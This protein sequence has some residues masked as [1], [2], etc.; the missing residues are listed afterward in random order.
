MWETA[1][2][3]W[4]TKGDNELLYW[5]WSPRND[6]QMNFP[7]YGYDEA[8]IT[9]IVAASSPWHPISKEVYQNS[10]VRSPSWKNGKSYYGYTLPLGNFDMG[11]PLFFEQY[12]FMGINPTGLTDSMGIDYWQQVKNHTW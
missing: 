5:H 2:W 7:V 10:W 9:Y 1:D 3:N 6:F 4:H 11:G 8:L 12:T